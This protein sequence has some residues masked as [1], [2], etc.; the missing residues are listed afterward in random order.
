[1]SVTRHPFDP[2]TDGRSESSRPIDADPLLSES[3]T[4][5]SRASSD[6][7]TEPA[8]TSPGV[9]YLLTGEFGFW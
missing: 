5:R 3:E 7:D 1:M 8:Y 6:A 9:Q 4:A 2:D